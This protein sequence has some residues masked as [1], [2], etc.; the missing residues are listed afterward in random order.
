[1]MECEL[2]RLQSGGIISPDEYSDWAAPIMPVLKADGTVRILADHKM[3]INHYSK[4]VGYPLPKA[5]DL[6]TTLMGGQTFAKLDLTNANAQMELDDDSK[7][8]TC[9]T[10]HR[11]LY[12]YNRCPF[13]I[14]SAAPIFQCKMETLLKTV[15]KTV[16]FQDDIL[17]TGKSQ[18]EH[19]ENLNKVLNWLSQAGLCLRREKCTFVA[20]EVEY[21]GH[22]ISCQGILPSPSKVE[23]IA[24]APMPQNSLELRSF[25]GMLTY[26]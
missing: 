23:T 21:L 1:M 15:P 6:F 25:L 8:Y 20:R 11:G 5:D 10:T 19:L 14:R 22:Q 2:D 4:L 12:M 26:F 13:V 16:V 17:V 7:P 3:M 9:I 18:S 24:N